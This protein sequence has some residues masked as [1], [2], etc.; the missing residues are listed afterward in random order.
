M[1]QHNAI[2]LPDALA[3]ERPASPGKGRYLYRATDTGAVSYW[4][5]SAWRTVYDPTATVN[6][7]QLQGR[8]VASDAPTNG[9]A[10]VWDAAQSRWEPGTVA[11]GGLVLTTSHTWTLRQGSG[12]AAESSGQVT[13]S[14][15]LGASFNGSNR[16]SA[17]APLSAG[18]TMALYARVVSLTGDSNTYAGI[19]LQNSAG[20]AENSLLFQ[21]QPSGAAQWG[22]ES[23]GGYTGYATVTAGSITIDGTWWLK[24]EID[25][26]GRARFC[27]GQGSGS[28]RPAHGEWLQ[29]GDHAITGWSGVGKLAFD[30]AF[31][32]LAQ[33]SSGA[34]SQVVFHNLTLETLSVS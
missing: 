16:P 18:R 23:G 33:T 5:G 7:T 9:Q 34:A 13:L 22:Y 6:A 12:T 17:Y 27:Y 19:S 11:G 21:L 15:A 24:I 10:L 3:S 4:D 32:Y 28:T 8:S 14:G 30:R 1:A 31:L 2:W 25:R 26:A 29:L 20:T